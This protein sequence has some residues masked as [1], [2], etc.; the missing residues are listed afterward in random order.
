MHTVSFFSFK[1]GVGRTNLLLNVAYALARDG[2]FVVIADWDLHAPG[3]TT[4]EKMAQPVPEGA[5]EATYPKGPDFRRGVLDYLDAIL[6]KDAQIPDPKTMALPTRLGREVEVE[7]P[8]KPGDIWFVPAGRFSANDENQEYLH[9]LLRVQSRNL[10]G[11]KLRFEEKGDVGDPLEVLKYFRSRLDLIEHDRLEKTPDFLLMDTQTGMTEIGDLLMSTDFTDQIILVSGLTGQSLAG[12]EAM[13]RRLQRN[14]FPGDISRYLSLVI[15][16]VPQEEGELTRDRFKRLYQLLERLS[17]YLEHE[18]R[19][20]MPSVHQIPYQSRIALTESLFSQQSPKNDLSSTV[21]GLV[22]E[23]QER[24]SL[25]QES[26]SRHAQAQVGASRNTSRHSDQPSKRHIFI[27]YHHGDAKEVSKLREELIASGE[28]V[29]WD[30]D[31]LPGENWKTA[32]HQA[33]KNSYAVLLCF[34]RETD[35]RPLLLALPEVAYAIDAYRELGPENILLIPVRLSKCVIPPLQI[36]ATRTLNILRS[37]DL[38]PPSE[39]SEHLQQLIQA[40]KSG[41]P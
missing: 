38:Y 17:R 22:R 8:L 23:I 4:M 27:S 3:L 10:A 35:V 7:A 29:W 25:M 30:R 6:Q 24:Q 26:S 18:E 12:L 33:I 19:E 1:G 9:Q 13:I 14:I 36:D 15:S 32:I 20:L 31:I 28:Q 2:A 40:F 5:D 16:P 11:W 21:L 39:R 34:S 37:V 41:A